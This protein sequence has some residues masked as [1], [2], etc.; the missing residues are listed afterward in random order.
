MKYMLDTN[1]CI[2]IMKHVPNV[3]SAFFQKKN[4]GVAI[5]AITQA[6]LE[7][8]LYNSNMQENNKNKLISFLSL[9]EILPFDGTAATSYGMIR[10]ELKR[11][12]TPIGN[13]D[14]LIA[15][16]AKSL[17]MTLVT[18]NTREFERV[19]GLIIEDWTI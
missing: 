15:A 4:D 18:N 7:F 17:N 6:E 16:H 13:M 12:G 5:S 8:G 9:V 2:F 3:L 19:K 10:T 1:I 11:N 14:M